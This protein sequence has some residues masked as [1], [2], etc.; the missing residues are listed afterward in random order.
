MLT[1]LPDGT[2]AVSRHP[3]RMAEM[4]DRTA[5]TSQLELRSRVFKQEPCRLF[6]FPYL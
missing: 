1:A 4:I 2:Q 5:H 6:L 3:A